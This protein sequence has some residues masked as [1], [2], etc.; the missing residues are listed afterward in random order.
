MNTDLVRSKLESFVAPDPM[1]RE[2]S[3]DPW[4]DFRE[5]EKIELHWEQT[6]R[7]SLGKYSKFFLELENRRLIATQCDHCGK[8]WLPPRPVCADDLHITHWTELTGRGTL[9]AFSV[10]HSAPA[11]I[12]EPIPYVLA[13]VRLDGA[14]TLLAHLIRNYGTLEN[15]RV[16]MRVQVAYAVQPVDHPIR[17]MWFEPA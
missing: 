13:Y 16:G 7:H 3:Q 14:S 1:A 15:V 9:E 2:R 11:F 10:L 5:V 17:L 4:R 12:N 8:V 6:Y